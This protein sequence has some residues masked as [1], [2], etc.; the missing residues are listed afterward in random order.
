MTNLVTVLV[1]SCDKYQ[2]TWTPFC[3]GFQKYWPDCPWPLCFTTNFLDSPCGQAIKV[4]KD[5]GWSKTF[6]IGLK[7][8]TSSVILHLAE[9]Y[10]LVEPVDTVALLQFSDIVLRGE[11]DYI[12]LCPGSNVRKRDSRPDSRLFVFADDSRYRT[13]LQAS[14]WRVEVLANL[15]RDDESCWQFES[16]GSKRSEKLVDR[17]L[18]VKENRYLQ[19]VQTGTLDYAQGPVVKYKWTASAQKY[20]LREELDLEIPVG[21]FV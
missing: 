10:W 4:G 12:L 5:R 19:Y 9:D 7:A 15:L 8:V 14:L 17:F 3:H 20:I 16:A 18:G 11:A 6:R 13:A 1:S 21:E 2:A